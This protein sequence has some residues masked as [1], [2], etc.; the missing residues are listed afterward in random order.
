MFSNKKESGEITVFL[1]LILTCICA[2]MCGLL[3][4]ARVAGSGWYLQMAADS[5][6]DSLMSKYH[7]DI[8]ENYHLLLLEYEDEEGLSKELEPYLVSYLNKESSYDLRDSRVRVLPPVKVTDENGK[9]F[10][11][12]ILDYMKLG[13]WTMEQDPEEIKSMFENIREADRLG[14]ITDRYQVDT[15]RVLDLERALDKIGECLK[16][17]GEYL[18][19]GKKKLKNCNGSGFIT[20]AKKL[21]R[22]LNKVPGLIKTYEKEADRLAGELE[23]SG[24][25]AE[26][27]SGDLKPDT[28]QMLLA[29]LNSYRTYTDKEGERRKAVEN[30]GLQ[31]VENERIVD[32]AIEEAEET[33][34]YIDT[35]EPDDEDDELDEEPL[36][37]DVH[38]TVSRF[39]VDPS[40]TV[41]EIRDKK[42]MNVLEGISRL[43]GGDLLSLVLP[44]GKEVSSASVNQSDFPTVTAAFTPAGVGKTMLGN[45]VDTVLI[46]EYAA[47]HFANFLSKEEKEFKYEQEYILNGA[48][49]DKENLRIMVNQ[50]LKVREAM[51]LI[52]LL[53]DSEKRGEADAL[54]A[55][56]TGAAGITPLAKIVS[57]FILTVWAFG[58]SLEDV[59]VLLRGGKVPFVKNNSDW[60]LSLGALLESGGKG[61]AAGVG[62]SIGGDGSAGGEGRGLDYQ[63][64]LR[65]FLLMQDKTVKD[66]RMMDMIQKN[67][68]IKQN[69]FRMM[70]SAYRVDMECIAKGRRASFKRNAAKAY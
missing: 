42:K 9:F 13:I 18:E 12:E 1:S 61:G 56:I 52:H 27:K 10:E 36:W 50:M 67:I 53:K 8:W 33:L 24:A 49:S 3:E 38:S 34:D 43:M 65:L 19:S 29:E 54:A 66:Y 30:V 69:G 41:P 60:K 57:F 51:N 47:H 55:V 39:R 26:E 25:Y 40:F 21:K 32:A 70:K 62:D 15:G 28:K 5:A 64:Y 11:Q 48:A 4:S 17:Q 31:A 2:L 7:R 14:E 68:G 22:E 63:S 44:E 59:R 37:N 16:K 23:E 46:N 20:D 35:W 45:P 6:L 58:E